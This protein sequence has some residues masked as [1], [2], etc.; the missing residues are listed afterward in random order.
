VG[1]IEVPAEVC[2]RIAATQAALAGHLLGAA[3]GRA[4]RDG[5]QVA[6]AGAPN[7]GKSSLFN[8]LVGEDRAIVTAHPGTTRDRVSASVE[9]EGAAFTFSDTA[10]LRESSDEIETMGMARTRDAI[11]SSH[12]VLWVVDAS[13]PAP[14]ETPPELGNRRVVVA[15]NKCD[16]G[17]T[18]QAAACALRQARDPGRVAQVSAKTG[19]GCI[20]LRETLVRTAGFEPGDVLASERQ[21]HECA[22]ACD[23]LARARECAV[24]GAPGEIVALE[25][26]EAMTALEE[27]LGVRVA[28]D[29]LDRIFARF[30]VGK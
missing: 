5:V 2:E 14:T 18:P 27:M 22:R 1:G 24:A 3:W 4:L 11:A 6:I 12:V 28:D 17:M 21:S 15:L 30:C 29:V 10:G 9:W 23:A 25:L 7:A 20:A 26:R 13:A 8:R 16:A 19:E